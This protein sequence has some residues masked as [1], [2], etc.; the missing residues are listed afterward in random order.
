LFKNFPILLE[1]SIDLIKEYSEADN[2]A[3][4]K[5]LDPIKKNSQVDSNVRDQLLI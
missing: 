2:N 1:A 5:I 3:Y 4:E